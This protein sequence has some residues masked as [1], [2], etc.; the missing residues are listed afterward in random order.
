MSGKKSS[1]ENSRAVLP[2]CIWV[3]RFLSIPGNNRPS[4]AEE[5]GRERRIVT[6][7][8]QVAGQQQ[9]I[10]RKPTAHQ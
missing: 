10:G 2:V 6:T 4:H 7:M 5:F 9:V 1:E 8:R 3:L